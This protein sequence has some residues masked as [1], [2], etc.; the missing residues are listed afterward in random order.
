[1]QLIIED[2]RLKDPERLSRLFALLAIAIRV[3]L[4]CR[5][6]ASGCRGADRQAA[7]GCANKS[8]SAQSL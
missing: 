8:S 2:T 4:C 5:P 1:M 6:I 3:G 7:A